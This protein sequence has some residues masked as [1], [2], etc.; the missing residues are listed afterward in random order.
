MVDNKV[1]LRGFYAQAL[2]ELR[3]GDAGELTSASYLGWAA[4]F[5]L[6]LDDFVISL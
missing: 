4:L 2:L 3:E 6:C 5:C 1:S